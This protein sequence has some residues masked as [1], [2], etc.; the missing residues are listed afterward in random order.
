MVSHYL[1]V[2]SWYTS[3]TFER[4]SHCDITVTRSTSVAGATMEELNSILLRFFLLF[5]RNIRAWVLEQSINRFSDSYQHNF[6]NKVVWRNINPSI[7][8][9][10]LHFWQLNDLMQSFS[11]V[12]EN[13][14]LRERRE[15]ILMDHV[16]KVGRQFCWRSYYSSHG[17]PYSVCVHV[18]S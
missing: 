4:I 6:Y 14:V 8:I 15:I 3:Y 1:T 10:T 13:A 11:V 9:L 18:P 12:F 2:H 16:Y 17:C 5:A 7:T